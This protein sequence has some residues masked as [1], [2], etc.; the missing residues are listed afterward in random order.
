MFSIFHLAAN[1]AIIAQPLQAEF[2]L[3]WMKWVTFTLK[4][5]GETKVEYYISRVFNGSACLIQ[6]SSTTRMFYQTSR[7]VLYEYRHVQNKVIPS[8]GFFDLTSG[9]RPTAPY[10]IVHVECNRKVCKTVENARAQSKCDYC[11]KPHMLLLG[12]CAVKDERKTTFNWVNGEILF[13]WLR[14]CRVTVRSGTRIHNKF[15][16]ALCYFVNVCAENL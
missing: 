15:R 5:F 13:P 6:T 2:D 10:R 14:N 16:S 8:F 12:E 4:E 7:K 1:H 9:L 3:K 11:M